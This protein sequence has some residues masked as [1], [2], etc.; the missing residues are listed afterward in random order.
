MNKHTATYDTIIHISLGLAAGL[1]A[2]FFAVLAVRLGASAWLLALIA[3]ALCSNAYRTGT[4]NSGF[5][6]GARGQAHQNQ[7]AVLYSIGAH[8]TQPH[9]TRLFKSVTRNSRNLNL[10]FTIPAILIRKNCS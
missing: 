8:Q 6:T 1:S 3:S 9:I 7:L 2:A 10:V 4:R 5:G